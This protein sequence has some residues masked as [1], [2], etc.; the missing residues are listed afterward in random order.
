L[1]AS[2][3]ELT[4]KALWLANTPSLAFPNIKSEL[5]TWIKDHLTDR[6]LENEGEQSSSAEN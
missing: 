6:P 3:D 2:T 5:V 4:Q 1:N